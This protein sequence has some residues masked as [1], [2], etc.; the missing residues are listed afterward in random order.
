MA[1][2]LGTFLAA[3]DVNVVGTSLPT[4]VGRLGGLKLYGWVFSAYLL[5]STTSVPLYGRL[6]DL[7]GR[8]PLYLAASALFML[9]SAL[10][11]VAGSMVTLILFR[12]VQGLGAG[13]LIPLTLT[14]FGDLYRAERRALIQGI[15]SVVWGV[16]SV[17]GPLVGGV[18]VTYFSWRWV[19]WVNI[20]LGIVSA[21]MLALS[22]REDVAD[23]HD[24][25]GLDLS[26]AL[27]VVTS[28][29]LL[30]VAVQHMGENGLTIGGLALAAA[31][32][33]AGGLLV[34]LERRSENPMFPP[35]IFGQRAAVVA[36]ACGLAL[37]CVLFSVMAM[38]PLYVQG[39]LH[40]S[41]TRAGLALVPMSITW[42]AVTFATGWL[43][44]RLGYRPV[45]ILGGL[46]LV[47]GAGLLLGGTS[48]RAMLWS[49]LG[50]ALLGV[51]MALV[52]TPM[53]ISVQDCMPW[54]LRGMTTAMMQFTRTVGGTLCVTVLGL[55]VTTRFT[56][57]LPA[58]QGLTRPGELLDP[59]RW[60][61]M[62]PRLLQQAQDALGLGMRGAF[63][64]ILGAA[65]ICLL[66][67][68]FFPP[69][70]MTQ[71]GHSGRS[72]ASPRSD[73]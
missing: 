28:L 53:T 54:N 60:A 3:L 8:R 12:A 63:W 37:G 56:A 11:G 50:M 40:G 72:D 34:L 51:G 49:Q 47:L 59:Q 66:V 16:S 4:V 25:P 48:A 41:P 2:L 9:G 21:V 44:R 7:Y 6:A 45:V 17:L 61:S 35:A 14:L 26:G 36:Y 55:L 31:G 62:P 27:V 13:G 58:A 30:L 29:S 67:L 5:T 18:I 38:V 39:V 70:R 43:S 15:F 46:A 33:A 32:L 65:T 19:F 71:G 64:A 42:T 57:A 20:P 69:L 52:F 68:L 10:C 73:P 23:R 24:R 1:L 22:L